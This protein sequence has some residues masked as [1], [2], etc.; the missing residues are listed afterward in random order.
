MNKKE[1]LEIEKRFIDPDAIEKTP[2]H[3]LL[4]NLRRG[5]KVCKNDNDNKNLDYEEKILSYNKAKAYLKSLKFE[6]RED[7]EKWYAENKPTFLPKNPQKYYKA[8][9]EEINCWNTLAAQGRQYEL[10]CDVDNPIHFY[11]LVEHDD[12]L[13]EEWKATEAIE[14]IDGYDIIGDLWWCDARLS[15]EEAIDWA[16]SLGDKFYLI[17]DDDGN[18]IGHG[19][20]DNNYHKN[21]EY[22]TEKYNMELEAEL[23]NE[24]DI[25]NTGD[26]LQQKE[27]EDFHRYYG[28]YDWP[29]WEVDLYLLQQEVEAE[30][31][32]PAQEMDGEIYTEFVHD[33]DDDLLELDG[34]IEDVIDYNEGNCAIMDVLFNNGIELED[35]YD[36]TTN[37][38]KD[39]RYVE[40]HC[41][42]LEQALPYIDNYQDENVYKYRINFGDDMKVI[43]KTSGDF[44]ESIFAVY[45]NNHFIGVTYDVD[46]IELIIDENN[47]KNINN[48]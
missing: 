1:M 7:Y 6:T 36:N 4:D 22:E 9:V 15:K 41:K 28:Y 16:I 8:R 33:L 3:I 20:F 45:H 14:N 34:E 32:W 12:D 13:V 48:K 10:L 44:S 40:I 30:N 39:G 37:T 26:L 19:Y 11:S 47:K 29:N 17:G 5:Q 24:A 43:R 2:M 35:M 38:D 31:E 23:E 25:D 42:D 27:I 21:R 46:K 18:I